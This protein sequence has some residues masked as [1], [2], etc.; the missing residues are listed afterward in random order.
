[1]TLTAL[2]AVKERLLCTLQQANNAIKERSLH[3]FYLP[4]T[5]NVFFSAA[6]FMLP[7]VVLSAFLP[8]LVNKD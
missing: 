6:D 4:L 3:F 2:C 5:V 8:F 1:M 7:A